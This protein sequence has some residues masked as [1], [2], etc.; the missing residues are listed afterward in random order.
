LPWW[1]RALPWLLGL[2]FLA[3]VL[4]VVH[5]FISSESVAPKGKNVA[6]GATI[7]VGTVSGD[8][9]IYIDALGT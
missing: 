7:N 6:A 4:L 2:S 8:S 3:L 1:R 9:N 5:S